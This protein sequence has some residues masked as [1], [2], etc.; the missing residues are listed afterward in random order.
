[1][2]KRFG[3]LLAKLTLPALVLLYPAI[4]NAQSSHGSGN[5]GLERD[6]QEAM[7]AQ[8]RGDLERA[9]AL[10]LKL[11]N[12]HPGLFAV[13]ES[14]GL[15]LASRGEVS[16]ALPLLEAAVR[17]QPSSDA[18]HAN[19]GA[20]LYNLHRN[21][22]ALDEFQRA[23][24]IN[25]GN[26][27]AQKSLGSLYMEIHKPDEAAKAL[28][29]AQRLNPEDSDLR[30]DCITALLAANRLDEAQQMLATV[31]NADRS[32]RAQSL[33]GEASEKAGNFHDAAQ[34]LAQ[35]AELEP[36]EENAWMLGVE[37][38]RHWTFAAA[39][40]EFEAASAKFPDSKR[41]RLGMAAAYFGDAQYAKAIP[42]F[43][44]LLGN[45]P[46]NSMYAEML[47]I[48]CTAPMDP[49][50]PRCSVLVTYAQAHPA[51]AKA[52]TYAATLLM[53]ENGDA[54]SLD[55]ARK[56]LARAIAADPNLPD[57]QF[58]MGVIVQNN[59]NWKECIPYFERAVKLKPDFAQAHYHLARAYFRIGR[60]QEGQAQID[61]QKKFAR[62]EQ[63]DL[64][65]RL[66]QIARFVVEFH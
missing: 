17:E 35:A 4:I 21:Q 11:H 33:L 6:F 5:A 40:T 37:F 32:A 26:A 52:A 62:Q 48:S 22:S 36:S 2:R 46:D 8:D 55:L 45:E 34:H 39:E 44:D 63:E 50:S 13:D 28:L 41:M 7:T 9:E 18:A 12:A 30:L 47:G 27:S 23:V 3:N 38:L 10:L 19:L 31:A 43:A 20:A 60:K 1:M 16:R 24:R 56:L 53:I 14:L 54:Q 29:E 65:R 66:R 64:D 51:D 42:V 58:Q 59:S 49:I 15:L 25:P 61:L 57:A